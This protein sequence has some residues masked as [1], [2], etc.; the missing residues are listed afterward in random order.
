[1]YLREKQFHEAFTTYERGL[2]QAGA[3]FGLYYGKG[4]SLS[5]LGDYAQASS[6]LDSA[7]AMSPGNAAALLYRGVV[8]LKQGAPRE[9]IAF[10]K[11][12]LRAD[13][14][15]EG[16]TYLVDAAVAV[17]DS[18]LAKAARA[19]SPGALDARIGR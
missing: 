18:A 4:A 16:W 12:S 8:A 5:M 1:M 2:R 10:L 13:P 17:G 7:L 19:R 3:D 6:A 9:A 14:N 11:Q 15:Q